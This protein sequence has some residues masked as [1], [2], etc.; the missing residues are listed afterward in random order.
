MTAYTSFQLI[1]SLEKMVEVSALSQ[2]MN[3][4]KYVHLVAAKHILRYLRGTV[5]YGLKYPINIVITLE[6]Y[7][8]SNWAGSVIDR[9]S[10]LGICFSLGHVV[11]SWTSKKQ[12]LVALNTTEAKLWLRKLLVG[13]FGQP[14][15]LTVIHCD[16]QSCIKMSANPVSHD[17]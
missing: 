14:W 12:L 9:E 8:D 11:I 17:R 10:T 2:F 4:L 7:S 5:G 6:G 16:N 13:L 15:E 1:P 3:K